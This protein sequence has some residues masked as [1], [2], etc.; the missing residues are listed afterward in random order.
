M[1]K[2]REILELNP[3]VPVVTF[4]ENDDPLAF[5]EFLLNQNVNCI[6]ITLRTSSGLSAI[7][8]IKKEFDNVKVGAGTVTNKDQIEK[9][10]DL[11]VDFMVSPGTTEKLIKEF[12]NSEI[13]FING[14]STASE[15]ILSKELGMDTLKFFPAHLYGGIAAIKIFGQLFPDIKFCPTGG[16]NVQTSK[17]YLA[18]TN[19]IAVGG[20]WFQ[21]DYKSLRK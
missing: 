21:K 12:I 19:V 8:R 14:V 6:E 3:L 4:H 16:I 10:S 1:N 5:M 2:I 18:Q 7:E 11:G 20:S 17:E 15:I 13:P 9:L